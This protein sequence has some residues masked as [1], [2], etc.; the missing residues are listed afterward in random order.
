MIRELWP[1]PE[2]SL[3]LILRLVGTGSPEA[4]QDASGRPSSVTG[5]TA[6]REDS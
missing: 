5:A 1:G 2:R 6:H 4:T 3:V